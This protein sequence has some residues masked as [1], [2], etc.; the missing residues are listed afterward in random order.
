[1]VTAMK[2]S[3][4]LRM[5]GVWLYKDSATEGATY[6]G[7]HIVFSTV[8]NSNPQLNP[9]PAISAGSTYE[10]SIQKTQTSLTVWFDGQIVYD[11]SCAAHSLLT[12]QSVWLSDNQGSAPT[13]ADVTINSLTIYDEI[14]PDTSATATGFEFLCFCSLLWLLFFVQNAAAWIPAIFSCRNPLRV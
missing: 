5:P 12:G 14:N 4:E 13:A 7:F 10:L 2:S 1:L 8:E 6:T 11:G 3:C 9:T